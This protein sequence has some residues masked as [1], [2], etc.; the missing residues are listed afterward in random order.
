VTQRY[1]IARGDTLSRI[2]KRVYGDA[3]LVERLARYNGLLDPD[4][5]AVGQ[6]IEIPSRRELEGTRLPKSSGPTNAET[7]TPPNGL[8]A[9]LA[10]FGNI[11][12]YLRDDGTL[13]PE[14]EAEF[15]TR[16]PLPFA[17]PFSVDRSTVIARLYCHLKLRDVFPA[18]FARMRDEGLETLVH[19]CG[20]CFNFR[21][22]RTSA[23]LSTHSWGIAIDLNPE[24]NAQS[25]AGDMAPEI[26]DIFRQAGFKWGGEWSG[27]DK[28]PMHF[29]FCTGY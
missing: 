9:I 8:D 1:V 5:I 13:K 20:G 7:L 26:V 4:V 15:L 24:T 16:A 12:D 29:Q 21:V 11:Y 17:I 19:S 23:K 18:V 22:K 10:T 6:T 3:A 28:D 27:R 25:T 14:W 2:A